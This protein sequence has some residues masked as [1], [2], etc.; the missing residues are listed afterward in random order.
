LG[1]PLFDC[2]KAREQ[3]GLTPRSAEEVVV[4]T[5][6]WA[7]F[8]GWLPEKLASSLRAKKSPESSWIAAATVST[9]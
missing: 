5:L 2:T 8:M 3:L 6:R 9:G 1:V 4:E 7:L